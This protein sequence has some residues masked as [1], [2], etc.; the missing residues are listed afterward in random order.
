MEKIRIRDKHPGSTKID[1][2]NENINGGGE[3]TV[4]A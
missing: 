1:C 3:G 2:K 4:N